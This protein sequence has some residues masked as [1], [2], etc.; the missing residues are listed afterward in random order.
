MSRSETKGKSK[1]KDI[2]YYII[3]VILLA[4]M[5]FSGFKVYQIASEYKKGTSA[6]DNLA[7][8]VGAVQ[9]SVPTSTAIEQVHLDTRLSLDWDKLK[10]KNS[11]IQG[12]LRCMGTVINYPIAQGSDN[13]YYLNHLID[14]TWNDKGTIFVDAKCQNPFNDFLTIT[15]GHRMRDKSMYY[16]LG[17]YFEE[18]EN[19]FFLEHPVMELYTSDKD[20]DLQIFGAAVIDSRDEN[21]YDF[22]LYN[23]DEKQAY[24]DWIFS[25]NQ[26]A[27]Y[28][29]RVSVMPSDHIMMMSTCTLRGSA[30]DDNRVVVW[31]KLVEVDRD[32]SGN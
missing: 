3:M 7:E 12:W 20:Y 31:G 16:L 23:D 28:D 21:L 4:I 27:G 24:I 13:E 29:N 5:A 30:N 25:H 17:E 19:P 9:E 15:Y 18:R 22:Y 14:G 26:L 32:V 11:E 1:K 10:E 2:A 8:E 6:Y